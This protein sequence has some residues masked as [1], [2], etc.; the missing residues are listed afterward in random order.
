MPELKRC[1]FCG[2]RGDVYCSNVAALNHVT[3]NKCGGS[4]E[5]NYPTPEDA[6][7]A[8]NRRTPSSHFADTE[9]T[10]A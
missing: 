8:W 9:A 5:L 3:C 7:A 4:T 10:D 6:I 2:E 1:P